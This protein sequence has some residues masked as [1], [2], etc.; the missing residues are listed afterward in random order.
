LVEKYN[1]TEGVPELK[2]AVEINPS[3]ADAFVGL[4]QAALQDYDFVEG[5]AFADQ[6]LEIN[7]SLPDALH[8]K[9]DLMLADGKTDAAVEQLKKAEAV[10]AVSEETLGRL[11]ACWHLKGKTAE[12][13]ALEKKILA[14]N[15]TPGVFYYRLADQMENRRQ[16][17]PAETYF[18]KSIAA[19][20]TYAA[21]KTGL[22]LL[23][24]RVGKEDDARKILAEAR[25][26]DPYHVRSLNFSKVLT[27]LEKYKPIVTEHYEVYV[28]P[29]K[30]ELLGK[31]MSEYLEATHGALCERFGYSPPGRT[32]IEIMVDHKWFSAR[33]V[34]LPSI[35]TVGA[36]TGE[37]V[38]L[39]SPRSLRTPYNWARVL[40]HEVVHIITLQQTK[41]NIP[42]WYTEALAVMAEGFPRS[43][44][45]DQLL[46]ERV[47][48]GDL[49]NLDTIN[50]AF[51][52]PKTQ[53]DW[54]MAY[55][56]S[57]QYA[58]YMLKRFGDRS[59]AKLLDAYRRGLETPQAIPE[60]FG[61][62][63]ADFEAGYTAHLKDLVATLKTGPAAKETSFSEAERA[64]RKSPED[65]DAAADLASHH[66]KR[67]NAAEARELA[68]K[69]LA[70]KPGHPLACYV[71]ARMEMSIGKTDEALKLLK[72]GFDAKNPDGRVMELLA[73][74][75]MKKKNYTEAAALYEQAHAA[76]PAARKWLEGLARVYL[77]EKKNDKLKP[78]L[79][80][81]AGMEADDA[82]VRKKLA[83]LAVGE[84][85]WKDADRWGREVLYIDVADASAHV[86]IGKAA[87]G[88]KRF[89]KAIEEL[90]IAFKLKADAEIRTALVDAYKAAG[91]DD[92]ARKV[93][94]RAVDAKKPQ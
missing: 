2:K 64:Y 60:T 61:V 37:V 86:A 84:G 65:P 46:A 8:L 21:A 22:G 67:K 16:F 90:E 52:R 68:E 7:P 35:G 71:L 23:Y 74:I 79:E 13:E 48:K 76:E 85:R 57:Q 6:A 89:D 11:A 40:T 27:H 75:E 66:L 14:V 53:L 32:K 49:L 87:L 58:E 51:V 5:N 70:A 91:N 36:C 45:W 80:K 1:K 34:G 43:E 3:A 12:A 81:L 93:Q 77:L 78:V 30:D 10:N 18:K 9:A 69:A 41:F 33:V 38:A 24:M 82:A 15:P 56:Q 25:E 55:C 88:E 39:A 63:I 28:D 62:T 20:P 47:P 92:E 31:Y 4:G 50:H 29:T 59:L 42:H 83:D 17:G 54:Q 19:A 26:Y 94:T 73:S 72:P 44:T